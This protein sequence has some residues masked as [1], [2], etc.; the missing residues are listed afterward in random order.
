MALVKHGSLLFIGHW[1]AFVASLSLLEASGLG[2]AQPREHSFNE[3]KFDCIETEPFAFVPAVRMT[4][5]LYRS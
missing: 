5:H 3:L 4:F 2:Q 1:R